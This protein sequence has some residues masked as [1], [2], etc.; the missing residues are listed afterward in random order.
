MSR[1][2]NSVLVAGVPRS[3]GTPTHF[4]HSDDMAFC[5]F[6]GNQVVEIHTPQ[7]TFPRI[8]EYLH[9]CHSNEA[10]MRAN[11]KNVNFAVA[12]TTEDC[13]IHLRHWPWYNRRHW[14]NPTMPEVIERDVR[15]WLRRELTA[16]NKATAGKVSGFPEF[17]VMLRQAAIRQGCGFKGSSLKNAGF[18]YG[19][20]MWKFAEQVLYEINSGNTKIAA[21]LIQMAFFGPKPPDIRPPE[22]EGDGEDSGERTGEMHETYETGLEQPPMHIVELPL[23]ERVP[24]AK[25][26]KRRKVFGPRLHRPS[27]RRNPL[28]QRLFVKK[29]GRKAGGTILVDASGSMGSF[30]EIIPWMEKAPFGT[31]AYYSGGTSDGELVIY[32]RNG[33]KADHFKHPHGGNTVDGPALDWLLQQPGPRIFITDRGFC[34]ASDSYA[35]IVR[36]REL[37]RQGVIK[38]FDYAHDAHE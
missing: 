6:A 13:V 7:D 4:E 24:G 23:T 29:S 36:L 11:Y 10:E 27:L 18:K 14:R 2:Q 12:Q 28:P 3:R 22:G 33:R 17:A 34:G 8:H 26:G 30:D 25:V 32:A 9:A 5:Q 15:K 37:E 31:I 16:M 19:D 1:N 35:Q 21:E 38:V 20:P